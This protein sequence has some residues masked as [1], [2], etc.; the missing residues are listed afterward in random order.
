MTPSL[1]FSPAW[2]SMTLTAL[3]SSL[4]GEREAPQ[5][6][7]HYQILCRFIPPELDFARPSLMRQTTLG[8]VQVSDGGE[9]L[10]DNLALGAAADSV[11]PDPLVCPLS[12]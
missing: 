2:G 5:F 4:T 9:E 10:S 1:T 11:T 6:S 8:S 7:S 3:S 12:L